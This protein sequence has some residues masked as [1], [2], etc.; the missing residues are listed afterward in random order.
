[1][2]AKES[3]VDVHLTRRT[4]YAIRTVDRRGGTAR[5]V[6]GFA[7]SSVTPRRR[8]SESKHGRGTGSRMTDDADRPEPD[9]AFEFEHD[10]SAPRQ[11]RQALR[12]LFPQHGQLAD[13]VGLVATELVSNVIRHTDDGGHMHAWDA[14]PL[15][16]EV[17]DS[18]SNLPARAG[19]ADERGG[20]GLRI[21]DDVA[22]E[23]GSRLDENGKTLWAEFRRPADGLAEPG[24]DSSR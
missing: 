7:V 6:G 13:D 9:V 24:D 20:H 16:L 10:A 14:D 18:D 15:R 19:Y 2:V 22:D 12:P 21:V 1:M 4:V 5:T 17:H 3:G 11:A 23:W 8:Q